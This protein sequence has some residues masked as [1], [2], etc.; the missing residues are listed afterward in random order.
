MEKFIRLFVLIMTFCVATPVMAQI[1][2]GGA[3]EKKTELTEAEK[4][5]AR[6]KALEA[7]KAAA[8]EEAAQGHKD[9]DKDREKAA[10]ARRKAAKEE[11]AKEA[12][13]EEAA[14]EEA[15]KE[16][17]AKEEAEPA[18]EGPVSGP[19][20]AHGNCYFGST[21]PKEGEQPRC[22]TIL[23]FKEGVKEEAREEVAEATEIEIQ[24]K[25]TIAA[26]VLLLLHLFFALWWRK[27]VVAAYSVAR[28]ALNVGQT[29]QQ[30]L[31]GLTAGP[32]RAAPPRSVSPS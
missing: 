32:S 9:P 27:K 24:T 15:A 1:D 2:L 22:L 31:Q 13:K 6:K 20:D 17:A 28:S 14:K 23:E 10:A 11:A 8:A 29:N 5:A 7:A 16:E 30:S 4:L 3:T 25:V 26:A 21:E 18:T 12:A 19:M